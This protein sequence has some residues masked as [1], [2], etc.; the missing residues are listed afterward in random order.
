MGRRS[1]LGLLFGGI[2]LY[3]PRALILTQACARPRERPRSKVSE[4]NFVRDP[5][6]VYACAHP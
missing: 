6:R 4:A 1:G 5:L 2:P 3:S